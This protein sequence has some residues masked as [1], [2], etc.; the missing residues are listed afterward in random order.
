M[1]AMK[2]IVNHGKRKGI[3]DIW[4]NAFMVSACKDW[5]DGDIPGCPTEKIEIPAKLLT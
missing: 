1:V 5:A 2:K 3:R 4:W